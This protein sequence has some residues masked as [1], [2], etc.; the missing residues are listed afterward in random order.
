MVIEDVMVQV[1]LGL[2]II[3]TV[4]MIL[5]LI[6][7]NSFFGSLEK[8]GKMIEK[9]L[10]QLDSGIDKLEKSAN[11]FSSKIKAFLEGIEKG[12]KIRDKIKEFWD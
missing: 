1:L 8:S 6:K 3:A 4:L 7:A 10:S 2:L 9:R 12:K 5:L 11:E